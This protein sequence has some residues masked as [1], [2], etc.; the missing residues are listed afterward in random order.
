MKINDS[1]TF[2]TS[3]VTKSDPGKVNITWEG[4]QKSSRIAL[5]LQRQCAFHFIKNGLRDPLEKKL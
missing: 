4:V 1:Y 3:Q 2:W 5:A